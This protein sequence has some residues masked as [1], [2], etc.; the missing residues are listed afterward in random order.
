MQILRLYF[1]LLQVGKPSLFFKTQII[2]ENTC[3]T[4]K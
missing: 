3:N 2:A 1:K 4:E